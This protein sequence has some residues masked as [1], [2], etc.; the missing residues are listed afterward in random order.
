MTGHARL[1]GASPTSVLRAIETGNPFTGDAGFAGR[2]GDGRLVRDVLG[3]VPL[4]IERGDPTTWSFAWAELDQPERVPA[5]TV[6][7]GGEAVT[8]WQLPSPEGF[9]N[10]EA[11]ID[12]VGTR[13]VQRCTDLDVA[14]AGIGFSGGVDSALL[15]S[16]FDTHLYAAGFPDSQDLEQA[17]AAAKA[18][19]RQ[20]EL[21]ELDHDDLRRAIPAVVRATGRQNAMDVAIGVSLFLVA[22]AVAEAGHE[23]LVLGQGADEL[24]GGYEKIATVDHRVSAE[25]SKEA[26]REV[27]AGISTG[28]E[29]DVL[30]VRAGGCEPVFPYLGDH[31]IQAGL[32]LNGSQLVREETRKWTLRQVAT[33]WLPPSIA[34]RDKKAIQYGNAVA[35]EID[36][37]ARQAGYK[38]RMPDHVGQYVSSL[39][40]SDED[41]STL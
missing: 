9:E 12:T 33:E 4:F 40:E 25:D 34:Q 24:F 31:V 22:E 17:R 11:A 18:M 32:R 3:R 2:L 10:D 13:F 14:D 16:Q 23:M 20:V 19:D 28:L 6:I 5:G 8:R 1:E 36:R 29:R 27:L 37:M 26:R 15:A 39:V 41:V 35:R 7:D 21:I 38:R 30:A